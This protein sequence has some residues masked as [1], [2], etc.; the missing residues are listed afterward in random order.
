MFVIEKRGRARSL[1]TVMPLLGPIVGLSAGGFLSEAAGWRWTPRSITIL[2]GV[3]EVAFFLFYRESYEPAVRRKEKEFRKV[4]VEI[5]FS[6]AQVTLGIIG[7]S[8]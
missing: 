8:S 2:V 6:S 4:T 5:L 1:M 7:A 3:Q